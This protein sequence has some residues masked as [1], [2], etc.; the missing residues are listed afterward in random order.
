MVRAIYGDKTDL[1][2]RESMGVITNDLQSVFKQKY[3][4][5]L[6]E[7]GRYILKKT[8]QFIFC[9]CD[10]NGGG[11]SQMALVSIVV[12][13]N[14]VVII[15]IDSHPVKGHE[16]IQ[17]LLVGHIE[18]IRKHTIFRDSWIIFI[19]EANLGHEA[20]H[21]E[22]MIRNYRRVYTIREKDRIGIMTTNVRKELYAME[23][24]RY[25]SQNSI[26]IYNKFI[27]TN[28]RGQPTLEQEE[29]HVIDVSN[30]KTPY[31]PLQKAA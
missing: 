7:K 6:F 27:T 22:F 1:L 23:T 19:P 28:T 9:C 18:G 4:D 20:D 8:P 16:Q 14:K 10:P 17:Q 13:L 25:L 15:A 30:K 31:T 3:V 5:K 12:E 11:T 26:D 24:T 2:Q 29:K 21:M